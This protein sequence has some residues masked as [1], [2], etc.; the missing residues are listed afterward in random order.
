MVHLQTSHFSL[1]TTTMT[2][3]ISNEQKQ[4]LLSSIQS[5]MECRKCTKQQLL[6]LIG[7]LSFA[8]KV[9]PAGRIFL[10]RL[11]DLSCSVSRIHHH[12]RLMKDAHIDMYWWLPQWNGT[13]CILQT[14]WTA[15]P[16]MTLGT[17]VS[18]SLVYALSFS[19][20]CESALSQKC[21]PTLPNPIHL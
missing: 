10:R 21:F 9:V 2:A 16:S 1:D 14:D 20:C 11:I 7:K 19:S 17:H 4:E 3:S 13:S 15:A 18:T 5:M 6:S 12:I 8:C